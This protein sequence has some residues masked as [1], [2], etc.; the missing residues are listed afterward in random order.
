M[1]SLNSLRVPRPPLPVLCRKAQTPARPETA[2]RQR[3]QARC[4]RIPPQPGHRPRPSDSPRGCGGRPTP[5]HRGVFSDPVTGGTVP[6]RSRLRRRARGPL[7]L[8]PP[9]AA[10]AVAVRARA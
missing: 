3:D 5:R 9:A 8:R 1:A 6:P 2:H 7:L 10:R 4:R